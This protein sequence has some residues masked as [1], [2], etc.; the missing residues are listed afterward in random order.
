M[1]IS[2]FDIGQKQKKNELKLYIISLNYTLCNRF[3]FFLDLITFISNLSK[4][5]IIAAP[6]TSLLKNRT[7]DPNIYNGSKC[8]NKHDVDILKKI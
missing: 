6:F 5:L 4:T 1:A 8:I 2:S 3:R 7:I